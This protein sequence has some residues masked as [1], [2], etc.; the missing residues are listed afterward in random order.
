MAPEDRT[1]DQLA[2][3]KEAPKAAAVVCYAKALY[4]YA[5]ENPEQEIDLLEGDVIAVE[6]KVSISPARRGFINH[7]PFTNNRH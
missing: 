2:Q 4:D 3:V 6:Y 1:K 5:S 7:S